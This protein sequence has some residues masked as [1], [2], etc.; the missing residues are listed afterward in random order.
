[1]IRALDLERGSIASTTSILPSCVERTRLASALRRRRAAG[2]AERVKELRKPSLSVWTVNRLARTQRNGSILLTLGIGSQSLSGHSSPAKP[3]CERASTAERGA[4]ARLSQAAQGIL[5]EH[6]STATIERVTATFGRRRWTAR[7]DLPAG[8]TLTSSR[9]WASGSREHG[10]TASVDVPP[11]TS[12]T[13]TSGAADG[14]QTRRDHSGLSQVELSQER[15]EL[16]RRAPPS[17]REERTARDEFS[18][19]DAP[20]SDPARRQTTADAV[21]AARTKL[22]GPAKLMRSARA[23]RSKRSS[24]TAVQVARVGRTDFELVLQRALLDV[25]RTERC[26]A[27]F[28]E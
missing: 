14:S 28:D 5:G 13:R 22:E 20:P 18:G 26:R 15:E 27:G 11:T 8:V 17:R 3:R 4:L 16:S 2:Q 21:E 10:E 6:G 9:G 7:Q 12:R 19:R 25:Q 23:S 1:M 24:L